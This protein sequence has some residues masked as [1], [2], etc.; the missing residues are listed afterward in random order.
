MGKFL[1]IGQK[2]SKIYIDGRNIEEFNIVLHIYAKTKEECEKKLAK[3]IA[4]KKAEFAQI[5]KAK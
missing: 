5:K 1:R 3:M 2:L 4:E